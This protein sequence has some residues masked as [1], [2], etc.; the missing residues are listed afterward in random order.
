M[1]ELIQRNKEIVA[2]NITIEASHNTRMES[3]IKVWWN[4][5][6]EEYDKDETICIL[7]MQNNIVKLD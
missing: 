6:H 2:E 7:H 4:A 3:R 5:F 1:A